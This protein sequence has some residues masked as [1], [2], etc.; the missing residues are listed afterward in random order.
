MWEIDRFKLFFRSVTGGYHAH[1]S[2]GD[3][4][5]VSRPF[6]RM[7]DW[8]ALQKCGAQKT[9]FKFFFI[10]YFNKNML[11]NNQWFHNASNHLK[12]SKLFRRRK[13][14][15]KRKNNNINNN[16]IQG[17]ILWCRLYHAFLSYPSLSFHAHSPRISLNTFRVFRNL[18]LSNLENVLQRNLT[19]GRECIFWESGGTN[20]KNGP[21]STPTMMATWWLRCSVCPKKLR[22]C[23]WL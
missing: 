20:L 8:F 10:L 18:N 9:I 12:I 3:I 16:N 2:R 15:Q 4:S 17:L 5:N 7:V 11:K 13:F 19:T 6:G 14:R 21:Q 1:N 22:I 23:H